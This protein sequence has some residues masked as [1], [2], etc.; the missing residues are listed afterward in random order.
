MIVPKPMPEVKLEDL[1]NN[2]KK[3]NVENYKSLL[4]KTTNY[5]DTHH[6][7]VP[8]LLVYGPTKLEHGHAIEYA[9]SK[10]PTKALYE[11]Y[12]WLNYRAERYQIANPKK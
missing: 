12:P 7:Y 11:S 8:G 4:Q 6:N 2:L 5:P 10:N 3:H 1:I 9:H